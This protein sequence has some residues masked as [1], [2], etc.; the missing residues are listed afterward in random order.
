[1]KITNLFQRT[2]TLLLAVF[3]YTSEI[4]STEEENFRE[5]EEAQQISRLLPTEEREEFAASTIHPA[6]P[7]E[8][9]QLVADFQMVMDHFEIPFFFSSGTLLGAER[10]GGM[11]AHDD[12]ADACILEE[13]FPKLVKKL[14]VFLELGY[15]YRIPNE[16]WRGIKI[17]KILE[18]ETRKIDVCLDV[19]MLTFKDGAYGYPTGWPWPRLTREQ[20]FPLKKIKFGH[21]RINAPHDIHDYLKQHYGR[22]W[23]TQVVKYNHLGLI[24]DEEQTSASPRFLP[25]GPLG[26][27]YDNST[28][29]TQA[30]ADFEENAVNQ[31]LDAVKEVPAL[32]QEIE[33]TPEL[34]L[35]DGFSI[36]QGQ[37]PSQK[38]SRWLIN[39][40]A[41]FLFN[42]SRGEGIYQI[43]LHGYTNGYIERVAFLHEDTEENKGL[44]VA[45][46]YGATMIFPNLEGSYPRRLILKMNSA[47]PCERDPESHECRDISFFLR[48]ATVTFTEPHTA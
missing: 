25:A 33:Y 31:L 29:L 40:C 1:M 34:K 16:G 46:E 11:I 18:I 17:E 19:F 9:Y 32:P 42:P 47:I 8:I 6:L 37:T 45:W 23:N 39:G 38:G 2:I 41:K 7:R 36:L 22:T 48:E 15:A 10:N 4:F 5:I 26:P 14:P 12:D 43:Q 20:I 27:I 24:G 13:D 35:I 44:P 30:F 3:V 21:V 28:I